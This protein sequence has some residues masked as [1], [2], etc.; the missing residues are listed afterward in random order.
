MLIL[1][2]ISVTRLTSLEFGQFI[3]STI[4][5]INIVTSVH[6]I[7]DA[8]FV[9]YLTD[10]ISKS[11]M[12]DKAVK[13]I[14]KNNE[15]AK[16]ASQDVRR[17]HAVTIARRSNSLYEFTDD[18]DEHNAY[19]SIE[20]VFGAYKGIQDWNMPEETKGI[21]R[22]VAELKDEA[23]LPQIE[24]LGIT[25]YVNKMDTENQAFKTLFEGRSVGEAGKEVFDV[26]AIRK[27][28]RTVYEDLAA[29]VLS[30][31]KGGK[32]EEFV[33][34]LNVLNNI[35][36]YYSDMLAK[37]KPAKEGEPPTPIPPMPNDD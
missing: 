37:R 33:A 21:E 25:K 8:V 1:V 32:Q 22:M 34:V 4:S 19:V 20:T 12:M 18:Q 35:R 23:H 11:L 28:T 29:Y 5:E 14:Q 10:L 27:E 3:S 31:A 7:T 26:K 16:I 24:L 30:I 6:P 15:T 13:Q 36:K 2:N 9:Q 17:D